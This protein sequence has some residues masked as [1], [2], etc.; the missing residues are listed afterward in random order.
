[1]CLFTSEPT[2]VASDRVLAAEDTPPRIAVL[3]GRRVCWLS[4][5]LFIDM[6]QPPFLLVEKRLILVALGAST[7]GD[8]KSTHNAIQDYGTVKNGESSDLEKVRF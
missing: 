2:G 4:L 1:M 5:N 6:R 3:G 7:N 8:Y